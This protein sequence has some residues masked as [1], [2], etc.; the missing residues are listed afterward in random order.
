MDDIQD[1]R[2]QMIDLRGTRVTYLVTSLGGFIAML[3]FVLGQSPLVMF[4]LLLFFGVL[5]QVA[6]DL[7]RL[8]RY[9]RGF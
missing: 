6:G 3:T 2:D 5:G 4:S 9:R 8:Y 7:S 1:E